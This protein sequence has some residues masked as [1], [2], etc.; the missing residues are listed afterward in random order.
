L[1]TIEKTAVSTRAE[2]AEMRPEKPRQFWV[3]MDSSAVSIR[4]MLELTYL[5]SGFI[6]CPLT[7]RIR[8]CAA[9]LQLSPVLTAVSRS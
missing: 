4:P 5:A 2:I 9:K 6:V 1:N 7:A 3:D 8:R